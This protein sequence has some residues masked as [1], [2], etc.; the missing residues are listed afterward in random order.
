MSLN[1]YAT[2]QEDYGMK[3]AKR[4]FHNASLVAVFLET[5]QHYQHKKNA[6]LFQD[7]TEL[8]QTTGQTSKTSSNALQQ[9]LQK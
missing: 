3:E 8:P 4:I 2:A 7:Y 6:K 5:L 9:L 1:L